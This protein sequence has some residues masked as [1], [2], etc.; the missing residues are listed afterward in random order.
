MSSKTLY[1]LA[2]ECER[3][4]ASPWISSHRRREIRRQADF[5]RSALS[6][7]DASDPTRL[8]LGWGTIITVQQRWATQHGYRCV[9][10]LGGV[11]LQ[12]GD[13]PV[14]VARIGDT[15]N[16]DGRRIRVEN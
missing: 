5:F 11:T 4:S 9:T 16:W 12:R 10:G 8:H 14:I 15:L 3:A 13:E 7:R 1:D 6:N 2:V